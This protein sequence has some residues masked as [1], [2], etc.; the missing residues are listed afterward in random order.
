MSPEAQVVLKELSSKVEKIY[1]K[2]LAEQ[3]Y[4]PQTEALRILCEYVKEQVKNENSN[5]SAS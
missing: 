1:D 4:N 3:G 5:S 2:V